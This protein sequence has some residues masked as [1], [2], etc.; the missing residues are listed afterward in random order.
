[1]VEQFSEQ[2]HKVMGDAVP[3][4]RVMKQHQP[5]SKDRQTVL[6]SIPNDAP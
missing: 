3:E 2:W 1:V 5:V 6:E 4:N